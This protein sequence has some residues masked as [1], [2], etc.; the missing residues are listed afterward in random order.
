MKIKSLG[1]KTD[2]M[3]FKKNALVED[4]KGYL[5]I[6]TLNNP[7]YFWG[8]LLIYPQGPKLGDFKDWITDFKNEFSEIKGINHITFAWDLTK[9][10]SFLKEFEDEGFDYDETIVLIAEDNLKTKY[11]NTEIKIKKILTDEEWES[12]INFQILVNPDNLNKDSYVPF[13]SKTYKNY[14]KLTE[15]GMGSWYGAF[16]GNEIVSD[17]GLFWEDGIARF[18]NIK[19]HPLHRKEGIAQTLMKKA[20]IDSGCSYFV[21]Q[22]EEDGPA[23]NMYKTIG[24][25]IKEII[26]GVCKYDK[27]KWDNP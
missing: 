18:Q 2:I 15:Q 4:R 27:K 22:A 26:G 19:T 17:L 24:F 7:D 10:A 11:E 25:K 20:S 8:N 3:F 5:C 9:E 6:K 14:R 23:I 1:I 21:I 16:K 13:I 12:I